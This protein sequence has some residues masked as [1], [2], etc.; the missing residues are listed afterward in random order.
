[1]LTC[2]KTIGGTISLGKTTIILIDSSFKRK[3]KDIT[4][5][6]AIKYGHD[7]YMGYYLT[8]YEVDVCENKCIEAAGTFYIVTVSFDY[9]FKFVYYNLPLLSVTSRVCNIK[10]NAI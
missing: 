6:P 10:R 2:T 8:F 4:N 5:E 7:Y 3:I 9:T 1:M